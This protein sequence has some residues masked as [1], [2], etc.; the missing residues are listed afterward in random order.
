MNN[1][2]EINFKYASTGFYQFNGPL[3]DFEIAGNDGV[4]YKANAKISGLKIIV[5]SA[6]V[7][8]PKMLRYGWKNYFE[9]TLF[10]IDKLPASSFF[11][12]DLSK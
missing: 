3:K 12:R 11:I 6:D 1:K 5:E 2:V 4:F 10:N 9:S 7:K 8:E